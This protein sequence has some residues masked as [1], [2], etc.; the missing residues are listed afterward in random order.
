MVILA[1]TEEW[2]PHSE[3]SNLHT[4]VARGGHLLS[5]GI[6][7]L[8]REVT[9]RGGQARGPTAPKSSDPLGAAPRAVVTGNHQL[10]GVLSDGLGI[11]STTSGVFSGFSSYQPFGS[12]GAHFS[13]EAGVGANVPTII[14]YRLHRGTVVNIGLPGFASHLSHD[15]DAKELVNQVWTVLDR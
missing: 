10:I 8:L 4:Y 11:F 3:L 13:S 1:G 6:G 14:G 12:A 15:V 2:L 7:S 9:I 5:F